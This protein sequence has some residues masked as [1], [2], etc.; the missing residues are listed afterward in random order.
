I[1]YLIS[2]KAGSLG[3]NLVSA[4]RVIIMDASWNPSYDSQAI[5]RAYRF[6]QEKEVFVYRLLAHGTLEQKIY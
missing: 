6:G 1:T 4:N 5:F 2:T 3:V